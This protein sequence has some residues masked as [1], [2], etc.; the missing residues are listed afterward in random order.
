[1]SLLAPLYALGI[2]MV[3]GPIIFHLWQRRP[4]R[5]QPFS[6]LMFL[7]PSVPRLTRRSRLNHVLLLL[8]RAAA[9]C[10]LA[11]A[12]MRPFWRALTQLTDT[13]APR[14]VV[15]LIDRSASMQREPLW[16]QAQEQARRVLDGLDGTDQVAV[17]AFDHTTEPLVEFS[18]T[19]A[20]ADVSR[21][22]AQDSLDALQP[23]WGSTDMGGA[24]RDAVDLLGNDDAVISGEKQIVLI[25][26]LQ[27]GARLDA[28]DNMTWP[29][30]IQLDVRQLQSSSNNASLQ[31][32][33]ADDAD[34]PDA[35]RVRVTN[36]SQD[37]LALR[38]FWGDQRNESESAPAKAV[39]VAGKRSRVVVIPRRASETRL[40]LLG[41]EQPFD[42][43]SY[44]APLR[45]VEKRVLFVGDVRDEQDRQFYY[46]K[47]TS[48]GTPQHPIRIATSPP[49]TVPTD[50]TPLDVPLVVL[51][52]D[53]PASWVP[54]LQ[55]YLATG[56][57]VLV[58][59]DPS[60]FSPRVEDSN[61][62]LATLLQ[63]PSVSTQL[64]TTDDYSMISAID[65]EHSLF[66]V[67]SEPQFNDFSK[68]RV[69]QYYHLTAD[70]EQPWRVLAR[71]DDQLPA[72]VEKEIGEGI[73]WVLT[74]GW[75]PKTSQLALST[76][77]V[78]L[79]A[80]MLGDTI[81]PPVHSNQVHVG[82]AIDFR[83]RGEFTHVV[84]PSGARVE[85]A[86][87]DE[88]FTE[89]GDVGVYQFIGPS[90]QWDVAVNMAPAESRIAPLE[91]ADL[92]QRGVL[93][94]KYESADAL[95][96]RDRQMRD[97]ELESRQKIWRWML[98]FA[99]SLLAIETYVSGRSD[100]NRGI[101]DDS[102]G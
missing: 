49:A 82:S 41:D 61:E 36:H 70:H 95:Q 24:L 6:S 55:E 54:S 53:V 88:R 35:L 17:L 32:V 14:R 97:V 81:E 75:N 99:L 25:S 78:P 63:L 48:L 26:D 101:E 58:V 3:A 34:S 72:L 79:L 62:T 46:L 67:F 76:K 87:A 10:A 56:G 65:Y 37:G 5:Q 83:Q 47:R 4:R 39:Q 27:Q 50:L 71:F 89:T 11:I 92:E 96:E 1:M 100:T 68:I 91:L 86:G 7:R 59:L 8:L 69:W 18:E 13:G 43:A 84:T 90:H 94:G 42:N 57:R 38:L 44:L 80:S 19:S 15:L 40:T 29:P 60:E 31:R 51:G 74:T 16:Q 23:G 30:D 93:M 45:P 73:V 33:P 66:Q 85:L 22:L 98:V 2:L 20:S 77:F 52:Q 21:S 9:I 12:F 64:A 28:L 102:E